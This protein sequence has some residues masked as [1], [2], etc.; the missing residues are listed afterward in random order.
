MKVIGFHNPDE[1]NGYF[2]NWYMVNFT[3]GDMSFSS[4]EQYMMYR[5]AICFHDGEIATKVLAS[6]DVAE[7]KNLGRHSLR[8]QG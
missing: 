1:V 5:K 8:P 7:I 3:V 2:S 6:D 4:M